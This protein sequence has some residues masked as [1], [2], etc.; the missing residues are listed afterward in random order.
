MFFYKI[1]VSHTQ[2]HEEGVS[3][4]TLRRKKKKNKKNLSWN[5]KNFGQYKRTQINDISFR[6][7]VSC[8]EKFG[9]VTHVVVHSLNVL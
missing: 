3:T 4:K 2:L 6:V 8:C 1:Q 7:D 9:H 5:L